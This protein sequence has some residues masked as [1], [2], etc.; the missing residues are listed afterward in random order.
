M[1][2][3]YAVLAP[4]GAR[5]FGGNGGRSWNFLPGRDGRDEAAFL[6]DVVDDAARRFG[7]D[8]DRVILAGFSAGGFMVNYLACAKPDAF[9]A[10]APV[11]GGFWRPI[12]A[13]CAGPIRLFHTHGWKDATVPLEGRYLRNKR[14][15]QGDIF[16]GLELW[17]AA[18][19]CPDEKPS[20][21]SE[22]GP[23]WRRVWSD[24]APGSALELALFAGGHTVPDGWADMVLGWFESQPRN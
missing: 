23:F 3:G 12:P 14:F 17:R 4:T 6:Q 10:Y 19:A 9:A 13:T 1:E 5:Q 15:Q 22:T 7:I 11:A 20:A 18:N 21:Y 16:A 24:C 2:R 8:T